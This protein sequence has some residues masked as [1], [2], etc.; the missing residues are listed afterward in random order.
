VLKSLNENLYSHLRLDA[1][2]IYCYGKHHCVNA[3]LYLGLELSHSIIVNS[4]HNDAKE[5]AD[6]RPDY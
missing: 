5:E 4:R 6:D 1:A 3:D 2:S